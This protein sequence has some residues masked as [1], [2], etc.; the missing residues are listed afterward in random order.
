M[1]QDRHRK[2]ILVVGVPRSGTTWVANT[3]A[4]APGTALLHEPDNE[5]QNI[6]ALRWKRNYHR[7]PHIEPSAEE[8]VYL[9][10]WRQILYESYLPN[11]T[12]INKTGFILMGLT[13]KKLEQY[14]QQK[15]EK[16]TVNESD[17][18]PQL[19]SQFVTSFLSQSSFSYQKQRTKRRIVKSVHTGLTLPF[20]SQHLS[21]EIVII[22]R[23][24]A[25][26]VS[27]CIQLHLSDADRKVFRQRNLM[28]AHLNPF[29]RKIEESKESVSAMALQTA[30]FYYVW[31][32]E[33][34][35]HPHWYFM[36]HEALC[37]DPI[38][39]FRSL[40]EKL[41]LDWMPS[42]EQFLAD[43][44]QPGAGFQISRESSTLKD[45]W[46]QTLTPE[47]IDQVKKGY[48]TLPVHL[49]DDF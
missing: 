17:A 2:P 31:E 19:P 8:S 23:H 15:C 45:K 40:Y 48:Q 3:L 20:I 16:L 10:F 47:Q 29:T 44:D 7:M 28:E 39:Q 14:V 32:Q 46:K 37:E 26:V 43:H 41:H 42:V 38:A 25:S 12:V 30:I 27:S 6:L 33:S 24:P 18:L 11:R 9:S 34:K 1:N 36:S 13:D 22:T 4:Q 49:Y 35:N 5:K 21:P